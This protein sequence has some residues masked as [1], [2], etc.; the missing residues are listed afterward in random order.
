MPYAHALIELSDGTR[1]KRGDPVEGEFDGYDALVES[2]AISDEPYDEESDKVGAP[3][4]V[5]IDGVVYVKANDGAEA[6]DVRT[7]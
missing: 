1:V 6:D 7:A 2:G 4:T 5:E 3:E